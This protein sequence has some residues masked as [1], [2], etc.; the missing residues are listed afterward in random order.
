MAALVSTNNKIF[1]PL[2][3]IE[4]SSSLK[5]FMKVAVIHFFGGWGGGHSVPC[6]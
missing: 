1:L 4:V 3:P 5:N 6:F 2:T